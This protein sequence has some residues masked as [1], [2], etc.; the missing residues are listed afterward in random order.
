MQ[1]YLRLHEGS[2]AHIETAFLMHAHSPL[3]QLIEFSGSVD[4]CKAVT[5]QVIGCNGQD[6][7]AELH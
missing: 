4:I 1:P 6:L 5:H 7:Q 2:K 3:S